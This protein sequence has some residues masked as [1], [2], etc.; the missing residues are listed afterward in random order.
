MALDP[1]TNSKLET[2]FTVAVTALYGCFLWNQ[3]FQVK[4]EGKEACFSGQTW[5]VPTQVSK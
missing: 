5:W 1:E 2:V 4:G 3:R